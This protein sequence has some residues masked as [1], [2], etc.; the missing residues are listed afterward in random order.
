MAGQ[1]EK[2]KRPSGGSKASQSLPEHEF[3]LYLDENLCNCAPVL[4]ALQK[5]NV[6]H[7]RH[8]SRFSSG[9]PDYEWLPYVG[10][11]GWALLTRDQNI[12]YQSIEHAQVVRYNV[13]EFVFKAGNLRKE[14]LAR[15][16][17]EAL[18][19]MQEVCRKYP[20]PFIASISKL[21]VVNMRF[22]RN[23][24]LHGRFAPARKRD[25]ESHG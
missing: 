3:V 24:P 14:E 6:R 1:S 25:G 9:T 4:E 12:R 11:N 2:S 20:P 7:E 22:D 5:N 15:V 23:G 17:I 16:L 19:K 21:G 8:L 18:P 10:Q 13:R